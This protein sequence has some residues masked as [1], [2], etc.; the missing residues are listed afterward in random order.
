MRERPPQAA[1]QAGFDRAFVTIFDSNLTTLFIA[2]I[3]LAFGTGPV[4]GFAVT[5]ALGIVTSMFTAITV[6]RAMVNLSYGGRQLKK[7]CR[8]EARP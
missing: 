4:K 2:I 5:L 6:T 8:C 3:L 1:I 7:L